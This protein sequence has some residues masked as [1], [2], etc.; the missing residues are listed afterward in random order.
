MIV[1]YIGFGKLVYLYRNTNQYL[2]Q[3]KLTAYTLVLAA[4]LTVAIFASYSAKNIVAT[5]SILPQI[6]KPVDLS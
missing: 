2:M 4:F 5:D 3:K 1:K 6:V